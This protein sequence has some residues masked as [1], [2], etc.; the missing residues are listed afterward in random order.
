M[1]TLPNQ[2]PTTNPHT[3]NTTHAHRTH[4]Q[5]QNHTHRTTPTEPHNPHTTPT[6]WLRPTLASPIFFC[7]LWL[8]L[9]W[10]SVLNCLFL[11]V[12]CVCVFRASL[13]DPP[14]PDRPPSARPPS[15]GPPKISLF[16]FPLPPQFFILFSLSCWSFSL[17]FGGVFE[18]QDPQMCTFGLL[19]C[20]VKP[21][22]PH[23]T[24]P[25]GLAHDNQRTPNVHI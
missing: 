25:P 12:C 15:A 2:P 24:G 22:R 9:V 20:R 17:N 21:Q 16:F 5:T 11:L 1:E 8:V 14:P 3:H 6:Q 18:D 19:G 10:E 4:T 23:Q 7:V 13:P